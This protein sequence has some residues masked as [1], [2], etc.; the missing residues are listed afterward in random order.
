MLMVGN[1]LTETVSMRDWLKK[2]AEEGSS[3]LYYM[4]TTTLGML[5]PE[6]EEEFG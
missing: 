4:S 3:F 5:M 2:Y 1:S 6:I